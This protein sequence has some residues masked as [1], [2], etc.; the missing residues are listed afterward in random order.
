MSVAPEMPFWQ[1]ASSRPASSPT[2]TQ[3]VDIGTLETFWK[4]KR[5]PPYTMLITAADRMSPTPDFS[6]TTSCTLSPPIRITT[7][8]PPTI[9]EQN[10][11]NCHQFSWRGKY[12]AMLAA[13]CISQTD[14]RN[15]ALTQSTGSQYAAGLLGSNFPVSSLS[16][17]AACIL[18]PPRKKTKPETTK[19]IT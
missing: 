16:F 18:A 6:S 2:N 4:K 17:Q 12:T 15:P 1:R 7:A 13:F 3:V 11:M 14:Q 8:S 19:A 5:I 10:K 9:G